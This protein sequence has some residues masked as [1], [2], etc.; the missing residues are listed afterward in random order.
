MN[1][2]V[3]IIIVIG[4]LGLIV[5]GV[6]SK[7]LAVP[8]GVQINNQSASE[9][10]SSST[11]ASTTTTISPVTGQKVIQPSMVKYYPE[12]SATT[13]SGGSAV[14]ADADF[15]IT[16]AQQAQMYLVDKYKPGICFG[17]P[18]A[19]TQN[20]INAELALDPRLAKF[21]KAY[22]QLATDLDTYNKL[23]QLR[24]ISLT[25]TKSG[26][27][28]YIFED[29]RCSDIVDYRGVVEVA[30]NRVSDNLITNK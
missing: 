1:K 6:F 24:G 17:M 8:S 23:K 26:T 20:L 9:T 25:E 11:A 7:Q 27:F 12:N 30:T 14:S 3:L 29:G 21:L 18:L 22:Y 2:V 15:I 13:G 28:D 4:C 16:P 19:P 10:G 5:W